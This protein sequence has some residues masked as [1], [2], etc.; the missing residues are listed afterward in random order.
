MPSPSSDPSPQVPSL[1]EENREAVAALLRSPQ[2]ALLRD[3]LMERQADLYRT[4]LASRGEDHWMVVGQLKELGALLDDRQVQFLLSTKSPLDT[5]PGPPRD[6][7]VM[8]RDIPMDG[9]L[10]HG[11]R[12]SLRSLGGE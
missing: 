8:D 10:G 3:R 6:S 1:E 4:S 5:P 7:D 2:L 12:R 9:Y 11:R